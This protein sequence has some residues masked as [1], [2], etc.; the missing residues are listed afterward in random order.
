MNESNFLLPLRSKM[1]NCYMAQVCAV[2]ASWLG[3]ASL[4]SGLKS[5][6]TGM[7]VIPHRS[8][9]G[10]FLAE[11]KGAAQ[12]ILLKLQTAVDSSHDA[13]SRRNISLAMVF[14]IVLASG[15]TQAKPTDAQIARNNFVQSIPV[16]PWL[17]LAETTIHEV[18][19]PIQQLK[20]QYQGALLIQ[21]GTSAETGGMFINL[22]MA[23]PE[24]MLNEPGLQML[25]LDFDERKI[26]QMVVF[27][28]NRGWKDRNLTP[29]VE[30]MTGRYR[31]LA[32]PDF[33]GD[34]D[35]E[36]TDKT[37][38]FDIGRFAI[39]VRLPQHGTYATATFTTKTILKRL[40]TVDSTIH[41]FGDMLDR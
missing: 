21:E 2:F 26:L 28:V 24:G 18:R 16:L 27:R 19:T 32:E 13:L 8:R 38:L 30:R 39:E 25:T 29:L 40:R 36:A 20:S 3:I 31:N 7:H 11:L 35:S 5:Y 41:I 1:I 17:K 14:A 9:G 33:L 22:S 34:P 23:L 6:S 12:Q 37:L 4:A 10:Q 15:A